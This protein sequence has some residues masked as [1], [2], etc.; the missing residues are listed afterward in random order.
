ME[1]RQV[2]SLMTSL[3]ILFTYWIAS[4]TAN[5]D[6]ELHVLRAQNNLQKASLERQ[7]KEIKALKKEIENLKTGPDHSEVD[8]LR[9]DLAQAQKRIEE[10]SKKIEEL[11]PVEKKNIKLTD[12]DLTPESVKKTNYSGAE[13]MLDGFVVETKAKEGEFMAII[14]AGVDDPHG[15][16]PLMVR[17]MNDK[18][19][20]KEYQ[21][22]IHVT[23]K[24]VA[25]LKASDLSHRVIGTIH[26]INVM[27]G[28]M[29]QRTV[30]SYAPKTEKGTLIIIHLDNIK[31]R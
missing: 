25:D 11:T 15:N 26:D 19:P 9:N 18:P 6:D 28:D 23:G 21:I 13:L 2:M 27:N 17:Q 20:Y 4:A 1:M 10:L 24:I 5:D 30:V 14:A 22:Q 16:H 12:R 7:N 31:I 3:I 29:H 8:K